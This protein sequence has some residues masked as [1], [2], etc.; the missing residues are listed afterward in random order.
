MPSTVIV[1]PLRRAVE[2]D[3]WPGTVTNVCPGLV[4]FHAC[5]PSLHTRGV[6]QR[7]TAIYTCKA[8]LTQT[9]GEFGVVVSIRVLRTVAASVVRTGI[10]TNFCK[11]ASHL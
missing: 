4:I 2:A 8:F 10:G 9:A 11:T 5:V 6:T 1:T 7:F 3:E